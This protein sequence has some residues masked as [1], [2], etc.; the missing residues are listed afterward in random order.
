MRSQPALRSFGHRLSCKI[1]IFM[2]KSD[3]EKSG[4]PSAAIHDF[5]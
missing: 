4:S 1:I 2:G 5:D 3:P